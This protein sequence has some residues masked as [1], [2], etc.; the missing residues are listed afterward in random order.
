MRWELRAQSLEAVILKTSIKSKRRQ[1]MRK[2]INIAAIAF[3]AVVSGA[4]PLY[5]QVAPQRDVLAEAQSGEGKNKA[6]ISV[7]LVAPGEAAVIV[8]FTSKKSKAKIEKMELVSPSGKRYTAESVRNMPSKDVDAYLNGLTSIHHKRGIDIAMFES[9]FVGQAY[10]NCGHCGGGSSRGERSGSGDKASAAIFA[11]LLS[12]IQVGVWCTIGVFRGLLDEE[13][14]WTIN[15]K[16]DDEGKRSSMKTNTELFKKFAKEHSGM[17]HKA[18]VNKGGTFVTATEES[19]A[20]KAQTPPAS[21][22]EPASGA[23]SG[24][25]YDPETGITTKVY[26]NPDGSRTVTQTDADGK[27]IRKEV[28]K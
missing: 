1:G 28:V 23:P 2:N 26:G 25:S 12:R 19:D 14:R 6:D 16:Y 3:L 18:G 8:Q 24:E 22:Q 15:V 4:F 13:G 7:V 21:A 17:E 10:A 5:A 9:I 20:S 27:E 11:G